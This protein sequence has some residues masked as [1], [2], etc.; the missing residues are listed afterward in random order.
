M[1][2]RFSRRVR[3]IDRSVIRVMFESANKNAINLALGQPDFD[4]PLHIKNAAIEAINEGFTK[5]TPNRGIPELIEGIRQKFHDENGLSFRPNEIMI[6]S[7]ASEALHL[8]IHSLIEEG[9]EVLFPDPGFISYAPLIL[10]AGGGTVG[11]PLREDL[12][13]D[14]DMVVEKITDRTKVLIINS[15]SNP[16]GAVQGEDDMR[17][18]AEIADDYGIT[19]ISDEVYEHLIYE[20]EHISPARFTDNIITINATSKTYAMTGWRLGYLAAREEYI[21]QML[22]VHGYIQACAP[23]I[24]QKAALAAITGSQDCVEEMRKVFHIRRDTVVGRL[25][26]IGLKFAIPKG[27]FYVFPY[28]SDE[29]KIVRDLAKNGVIVTPGSA[30]GVNGK[31]HIRISYAAPI[32]QLNEAFDIIERVITEIGD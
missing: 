9:G 26:D 32:P 25:R 1:K 2:E 6:T 29:S 11:V 27:A 13:M 24:S 17:A 18:F 22:K 8:A 10:L 3:N 28:V 15:P 21:E 4:T 23:S 20:G 31:D 19:I 16:T 30:F 12:S 5:Y 7:G 14:P